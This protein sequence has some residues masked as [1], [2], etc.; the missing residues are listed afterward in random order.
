[1]EDGEIYT[2]GGRVLNVTGYASSL[3]EARDL[4]YR[5]VEEI[6]FSGMHYR[7]DIAESAL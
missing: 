4:A 5:A 7:T 1:L 2:A 6:N 3:G